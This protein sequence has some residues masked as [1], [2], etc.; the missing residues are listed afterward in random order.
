MPRNPTPAQSAASRTNARRSTGPTSAEGK[1]RSAQNALTYGLRSAELSFVPGDDRAMFDL[2]EASIRAHFQPAS[3][4]EAALCARMVTAL[5]RTERAEDLDR[6]FW[7]GLPEGVQ[8][9]H[10]MARLHVLD[11]D[12][13]Q[14]R[15]TLPTI[16][17]YLA[18]ADRAFAR[19]LRH[20]EQIRQGI[21]LPLADAPDADAPTVPICTNEPEPPATDA[22]GAEVT[23]EPA[24]AAICTN[25][26]ERPAPLL[27]SP[28]LTGGP[29]AGRSPP[30]DPPPSR[31]VTEGQSRTNEPEHTEN[32]TNEPENR[33]AMRAAGPADNAANEPESGPE[34]TEFDTNEPEI[35]TAAAPASGDLARQ[36]ET[37]V[38]L[39]QLAELRRQIA[40]RWPDDRDAAEACFLAKHPPIWL[41]DLPCGTPLA[42]RG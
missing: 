28:G 3:P 33:V 30:V 18:E 26:P 12:Q 8:P 14:R 24:V 13:I 21:G 35:A 15:P 37:V 20:L 40:A 38:A 25:E 19:A 6:T 4:L 36:I 31:R 2:L 39:D 10:V 22:A 11:H 5:W 34:C 32:D 16:L 42:G 1:A 17:R 7:M 27:S 9:G 29:T 41:A 23:V